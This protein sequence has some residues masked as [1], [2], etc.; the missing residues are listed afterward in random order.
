MTTFTFPRQL[1]VIRD[2]MVKDNTIFALL[3]TAEEKIGRLVQMD[4]EGT[5]LKQCRVPFT[6]SPFFTANALGK[7]IRFWD[8]YKGHYYYLDFIE[9][10]DAWLLKRARL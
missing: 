2:L 7:I 8:V 9:E 5:M 10:D 6:P 4:E 1:P 3:Y